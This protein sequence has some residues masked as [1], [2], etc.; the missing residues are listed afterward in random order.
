MQFA[1]TITNLQVTFRRKVF[2]LT[3]FA[4]IIILYFLPETL[5][6]TGLN[7]YSYC[8]H[9]QIFGF[10]CPGCGLTRATY[11]FLHLEYQKAF[12]LNP[13]VVFA[14]P[15]IVSELSYQ[16]KQNERLRKIRFIL[17]LLFCNS[18][19]ILYLIRIFNH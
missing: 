14:F 15:T 8:L 13:S 18:L 9:K 7:E 1:K 16:I 11:Y 17:Y 19:L 10:N 2:V 12:S 5:F 3:V 4:A 6:M